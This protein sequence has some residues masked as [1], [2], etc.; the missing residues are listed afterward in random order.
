MC[1]LPV[2]VS[3]P[4]MDLY[5][6][7]C[8]SAPIDRLLWDMYMFSMRLKLLLKKLTKKSENLS[9]NVILS[10]NVFLDLHL[11]PDIQQS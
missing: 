4:G 5:P 11:D 3:L 2:Y 1:R 8:H 9:H 7:L 10:F 6:D